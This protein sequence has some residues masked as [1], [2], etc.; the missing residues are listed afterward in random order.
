MRPARLTTAAVIRKAD[1]HSPTHVY[2]GRNGMPRGAVHANSAVVNVSV[3]PVGP[4][5]VM[6]WPASVEYAMP[7][8][9]R[10][11]I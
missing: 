5:K 7:H 9:P 6:G 1:V 2:M 3:R 10:D 11:K 4:M 8:A